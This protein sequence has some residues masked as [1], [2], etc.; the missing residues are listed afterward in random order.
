MSKKVTI[1]LKELLEEITAELQE[2]AI[3]EFNEQLN[4]TINNVVKEA[5]K[6]FATKRFRPSDKDDFDERYLYSKEEVELFK[7]L[8][9]NPNVKIRTEY[10]E[11]F[12]NEIYC[13]IL[14]R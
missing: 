10:K 12:P 9:K 1:N 2:Q 13:Y 8:N 14:Y 3:R 4:S 5:V 11:K 6:H 7:K